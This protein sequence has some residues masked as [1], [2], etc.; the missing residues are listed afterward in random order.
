MALLVLL[1]V[2]LVV[3]LV[4]VLVVLLLAVVATPLFYSSGS[5]NKQSLNKI[6]VFKIDALRRSRFAFALRSCLQDL[7]QATQICIQILYV[8]S[9][10][11]QNPQ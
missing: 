4:V 9:A 10:Y 5:T 8:S 11:W 3:V 1:V 7:L 2:L 6:P